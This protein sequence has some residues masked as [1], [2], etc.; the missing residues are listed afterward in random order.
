MLSTQ[1]YLL[2][3]GQAINSKL[4]FIGNIAEN[5]SGEM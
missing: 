1:H 2:A 4:E 5:K 3:S